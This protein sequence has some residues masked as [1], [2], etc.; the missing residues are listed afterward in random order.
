MDH[1]YPQD[2]A[3]AER[4][5]STGTDETSTA[6]EETLSFTM[7]ETYTETESEYDDLDDPDRYDADKEKIFAA[8][9]TQDYVVFHP[10]THAVDAATVPMLIQ[11]LT[12]PS[13]ADPNLQFIFVLTFQY[14]IKPTAIMELLQLR[15]SQV[16]QP[17]LH[18]FDGPEMMAWRKE[19]MMPTLLRLLNLVKMLVAVHPMLIRTSH[20]FYD[21]IYKLIDTM[22][23]VH[24]TGAANLKN[25]LEKQVVEVVTVHMDRAPQFSR[26]PPKPKLT[27]AFFECHL[28]SDLEFSHLTPLEVAR[29]LTLLDHRLYRAIRPEELLLQNWTKEGT[30]EIFSSN[31]LASIRHF[32]NIGKWVVTEIVSTPDLDKRVA[33]LARFIKTVNECLKLHNFNGAMAIISGLQNHSVYRLTKTWESLPSATWAVWE[34]VTERLKCDNNYSNLRRILKATSPPCVPYLGMY[35]SELTFISNESSWT[36]S[37]RLVNVVKLRFITNI[38]LAVQTF[39]NT[40]YE[41]ESVDMIQRYLQ[42]FYEATEDDL[43]A[44]SLECEERQGSLVEPMSKRKK[45]LKK[46]ELKRSKRKMSS[47]SSSSSSSSAPPAKGKLKASKILRASTSLQSKLKPR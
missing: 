18:I 12:D 43:Y 17:P 44:L 23:L 34:A 11:L 2:S 32:C 14:V 39:Q 20:E 31:V 7:Q 40:R 28:V 3:V 33:S 27:K 29:Q 16:I 6:M 41:L 45:K 30:K 24:A 46:K 26:Q 37:R 47:S 22:A 36:E 9:L 13:T 10:E 42:T 38:I 8:P 4:D 19:C 25:H 21:A 35:L 15:L 5:M 1:V